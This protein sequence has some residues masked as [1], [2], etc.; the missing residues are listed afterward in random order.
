MYL[1]KYL[2]NIFKLIIPFQSFI[3]CKKYEYSECSY[4]DTINYVECIIYLNKNNSFIKNCINIAGIEDMYKSNFYFTVPQKYNCSNKNNEE[5]YKYIMDPYL[6]A[7]Q[8][9]ID[10]KIK[11]YHNNIFNCNKIN[12]KI[13]FGKRYKCFLNN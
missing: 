4:Q 3:T 2:T 12:N 6:E 11:K 8:C 7:T 5:T 13:D 9:F 1:I 10:L